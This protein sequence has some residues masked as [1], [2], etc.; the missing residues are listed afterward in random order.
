[1]KKPK[2]KDIGVL[3]NG[4][5]GNFTISWGSALDYYAILLKKLKWFRLFQELN[6]YSRNVG[7]LDY[8]EYRIIA[9]IAFPIIDRIFS[10]ELILKSYH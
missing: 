6:Q 2:R 10:K 8:V 1:M 4:D 5:R 3:L 9:R 7:G